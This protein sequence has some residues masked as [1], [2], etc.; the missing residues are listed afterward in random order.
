MSIYIASSIVFKNLLASH[1][2]LLYYQ[3]GHHYVSV[4][5]PAEQDKRSRAIPGVAA[6][7]LEKATYLSVV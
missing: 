5:N 1:K 7:V 3:S 2:P 4:N 6:C